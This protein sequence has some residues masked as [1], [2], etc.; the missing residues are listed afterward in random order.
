MQRYC[1]QVG[2]GL[3]QC[4]VNQGDRIVITVDYRM[5]N[6]KIATATTEASRYLSSHDEGYS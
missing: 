2:L 5:A 1:L 3:L 4:Y 6:C